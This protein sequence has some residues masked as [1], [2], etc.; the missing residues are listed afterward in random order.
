MRLVFVTP[1]FPPAAGSGVQRGAKFV[2]YL[3]RLGWEVRVVTIDPSVHPDR[4]PELEVPGVQVDAVKPVRLPGVEHT[5]LRALPGMRRA[6]ER[7][8]CEHRPDVLLATTPDYH[9]VLAARA[10]RRAG[11]P[12]GLDYP[13]PWTVLPDDFRI[14]GGP[15]KLRSHLKWALAPRVE[16]RL[17]ARAAFA[18]FATEPLKR[19]YVLERYVSAAKA[20]VLEN[21]FDEEDFEGVKPLARQ[22]GVRVAHVGSFGGPRTPMAAARA[23]AHAAKTLGGLELALVGAGVEPFRSQLEQALGDVPLRATGWVP[24]AAA[25]REML[26]ADVLWLDAM[27]H[28]RSASTGKIYEYLRAGKPIVAVAHPLSPAAGLVRRM[29]AG[30]VVSGEDPVEAGEALVAAVADPPSGPSVAD[31]ARFDRAALAER[32]SALL[33]G[34]AQ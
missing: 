12:F 32:L 5:V 19:E 23:V 34:V 26:S 3:T 1:Y 28:L 22:G 27:V 33:R 8:V 17:L 11:I 15:E 29:D 6:I 20:H 25:I 2:K 24:H 13:D 14:W 9:W 16:R 7:A 31:L 10:A 4:D 30:L 21:G 18:T